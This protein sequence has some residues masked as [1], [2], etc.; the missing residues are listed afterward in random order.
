MRYRSFFNKYFFIVIGIFLFYNTLYSQGEHTAIPY[1]SNGAQFGYYEYLPVNYVNENNHPLLIFLHGYGERGNGG[2]QLNKVLR[3]GPP[4]LIEQNKWP[5]SLPF[6]V[7]SPQVA[8]GFFN[9]GRMDQFI[10]FLIK[11]Y[12]VDNNRVYITG[13]SAGG[14][15][16]WNYLSHHHDKVAAVVPIAGNGNTPIRD[17]KCAFSNVPIWAFHGDRDKTV[18]P[19]GSTGPVTYIKENCAPEVKPKVT[20]FKGVKHN[21]WSRV[22][23]LSGMNDEFDPEYEPYD[24]D[25]YTWMLQFSLEDD[26]IE[27]VDFIANPLEID[28]NSFPN[29]IFNAKA[30]DNNGNIKNIYLNLVALG[31]DDKV[32]MIPLGNN[33]YILEYLIDQ[34]LPKGK[35]TVVLTVVDNDGNKQFKQID[36]NVVNR[37][38][39]A[40]S[41]LSLEKVSSSSAKL[42]WKDNSTGETGFLIEMKIG[43][44]D[45][46][47]I[48]TADANKTETVIENL[49]CNEI[50][51]FRLAASSPTNNSDYSNTEKVKLFN[52]TKIKIKVENLSSPVCSGDTV[53]LSLPEGY[54]AYIWSN[55]D[56]TRAINVLDDGFYFG[57]AKDVNGCW[58]LNSDTV[59]FFFEA[60]PEKPNIISEDK[61]TKCIDDTVTLNA[62][63]GYEQYFWSNDSTNAQLN[64]AEEDAY[65]IKVLAVNGCWSRWSDVYEIKN[66]STPDKPKIIKSDTGS[67]CEGDSVWLKTENKYNFYNWNDSIYTDS[68]K[69][70]ASKTYVLKVANCQDEWSSSDTMQ[71]D[72]RPVP[73]K[74]IL[75]F[76]GS[77]SIC[78]GENTDIYSSQA[79]I[80]YLWNDNTTQDTL[81]ADQSGFYYLYG[82]NEFGCQSIPSDSIELKV[83]TAPGV[84][85][86]NADQSLPKCLHDTVRVFVTD[87]FDEFQWSNN[88]TTQS[89]SIAVEDTLTVRVKS[90]N[91]CWSQWSEDFEIKNYEKPEKPIIIK[92]DTSKLC[93]GEM[94]QIFTKKQYNFF[95]WSTGETQDSIEVDESKIYAVRVAM[96][97]NDWSEYDSIDIFFNDIPQRPTLSYSGDLTYC[98]G[99]GKTKL[100]S[101]DVYYSYQWN[102]G[103]NGDTL[104][105]N[106]TGNYFLSGINEVGCF[107]INSDTLEVKINPNPD[108]PII[109]TNIGNPKCLSDTVKLSAPTGFNAYLWSDNFSGQT[110]RT[111]EEGK[112]NLKVANSFNCWST[113]SDT[114]I[115]E[116]FNVPVKPS[117][118]VN[119][120]D[121]LCDGKDIKISTVD[122]YKYYQWQDDD[123][124]ESRV[125]TSSAVY[126]VRVANCVGDWSP[127]SEEK[128]IKINVSP[129]KPQIDASSLQICEGEISVFSVN[130]IFDHYQWNNG[131]QTRSFSTDNSGDYF[132][133]V[134]NEYQCFS[135]YSDTLKLEILPTPDQPEFI[136]AGTTLKCSSDS[137][138]I[139]TKEEHAKYKWND[140]IAVAERIIYQPGTYSLIVENEY[141]CSSVSSAI[142]S[143]ENI[144]IPDQPVIQQVGNGL[145]C[146]GQDIKLW[147]NSGYNY[148]QWSNNGVNND[149][150]PLKSGNYTVKVANCPNEWSITSLP[151]SVQINPVPSQPVIESNKNSYCQGESASLTTTEV[152]SAYKWNS[153]ETTK[154]ISTNQAGTYNVRV[155]NQFDCW[156]ST[157]TNELLAFFPTPTKPRIRNIGPTEF[158]RDE[159]ATKLEAPANFQQYLWNTNQ[160]IQTIEVN[161]SGNYQVK[162]KN[163]FGCWSPFSNAKEI[164]VF[165]KPEMPIIYAE[166]PIEICE[167][168]EVTLT[169]PENYVD[170]YWNSGENTSTIK[171][172]TQQNYKLRVKNELC[173]SEPSNL[174]SVK[175]TR[176]PNAP[177]IKVDDDLI[178]CPGEAIELYTNKEYLQYKWSEGSN[179]SVLVV[180]ETGN[181][182]LQVSNCKD[183]WSDASQPIFIEK[184]SDLEQPVIIYKNDSLTITQPQRYIS[185]QWKLNNSPIIGADN[186]FYFPFND[187]NYN[188]LAIE[189]NGCKINSEVFYFSFDFEEIVV[190]PNPSSGQF[191][192]RV[193]DTSINRGVLNIFNSQNKLILSKKF[194]KLVDYH[195][196]FIFDL[197]ARDRGVYIIQIVTNEDLISEKILIRD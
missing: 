162:V 85:K 192:I 108:K 110:F 80:S 83:K 113:W 51:I 45:F 97:K 147:V 95:E 149:I 189:E 38:F 163:T 48:S 90:E 44:D 94:V 107:S 131:E 176:T 68:L 184:I 53:N 188:L 20:I 81:I 154:T 60:R 6:L 112:F 67:L 174:I 47:E 165:D 117:L 141:Q 167:G 59:E 158:C 41:D 129:A 194:E 186:Y 65:K 193:I 21:S 181:Y 2:S 157:S 139:T 98:E 121:G 102:N 196:P 69:V 140:G 103:E 35:K 84:P 116:N 64:V 190:Y 177:V 195:L 28:N 145:Y 118:E 123:L 135:E 29:I 54:K 134:Q 197:S 37:I 91:G 122:S 164:K 161:Q 182:K 128:Q 126:K 160:D 76:E 49:P 88:F 132:V 36:F 15:S 56:T 152:F 66:F 101:D 155:K 13:L 99:N 70:D 151:S 39:P 14:I 24:I 170:Y 150:Y 75:D 183:A 58:T 71:V 89:F 142:V 169:G 125:I 124:T 33:S 93:Q 31:G 104:D 159:N 115:I 34:V 130:Q 146:E 8:N 105:I 17:V 166:G 175:V 100:F 191:R 111:Y 46:K 178:L 23:D 57:R 133:R 61:S 50:L 26:G 32:D 72:F 92:S 172:F 7:I 5:D 179:S 109:T 144:P 22:Y 106:K 3:N 40:P 12:K 25:I 9:P 18:N 119:A 78:E 30:L 171:V 173:W 86:I 11:K 114:I 43:E 16:A 156:N 87:T 138:Y 1:G 10:D 143:I 168:E 136:I 185:Y 120:P 73:A 127:F 74:P 77:L 42:F 52:N 137:V 63:E 27:I 148:Y 79:Y 187:G 153:G 4:K 19:G 180:N 82:L 55:E 62:P 96:C